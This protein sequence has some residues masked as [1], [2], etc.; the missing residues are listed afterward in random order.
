M[1]GRYRP[2]RLLGRGASSEVHLATD[3]QTG[4]PV[5]LKR[6]AGTDVPLTLQQGGQRETL[7]ASRLQHAGIAAV[8]DADPSGRGAWLVTAYAA[9]VPLALDE[10]P[11]FRTFRIGLFGLDKLKNPDRTV[12]SFEQALNRL[13]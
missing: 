1:A 8:L 10:G 13:L 6:M 2:E 4:Q 7:A 11:D 9:G 5:A 3:L 12:A